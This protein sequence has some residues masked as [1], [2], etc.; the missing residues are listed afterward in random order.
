MRNRVICPCGT[1]GPESGNL[2]ASRAC[3]FLSTSSESI[4]NCH[5]CVDVSFFHL[6]SFFPVIRLFLCQL[7]FRLFTTML[8]TLR[9]ASR[10][11][12]SRESGVRVLMTVRAGST[13]ANVPQGPP[14]CHFEL[15]EEAVY[16][17]LMIYD[18]RTLSWVSLKLSRRT[19]LRRRSTWVLEPTV[20]SFPPRQANN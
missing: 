2:P 17:E 9:V 7:Q 1:T 5:L 18:D 11:A 19:L 12:V 10:Q 16:I 3:A 8:S 20:C 13:W 14:V 6:L 4:I 15:K